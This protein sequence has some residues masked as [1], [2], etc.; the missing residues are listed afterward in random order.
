[1]NNNIFMLYRDF[2][3]KEIYY[4]IRQNISNIRY[5]KEDLNMNSDIIVFYC[6]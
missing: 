5:L 3:D 1:M 2:E 4:Q 6:I